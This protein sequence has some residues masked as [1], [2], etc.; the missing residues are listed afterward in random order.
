MKKIYKDKIK[1]TLALLMVITL[2]SFCFIYYIEIYN[3][4]FFSSE[5]IKFVTLIKD[6]AQKNHDNPSLF[7]EKYNN[8]N[9]DEEKMKIVLTNNFYECVSKHETLIKTKI[10]VNLY[11]GHYIRF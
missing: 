10:D 5:D 2:V 8:A 4:L 9:T 7:L 6:M 3:I 1:L 11:C